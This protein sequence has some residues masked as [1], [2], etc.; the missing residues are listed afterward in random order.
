MQHI[1]LSG[2]STSTSNIQWIS[3]MHCKS[4]EYTGL[5]F[6]IRMEGDAVNWTKVTL[7]PAKLF[8]KDHMVK[9]S[10]EFANSC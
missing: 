5:P 2:H 1:W 4:N 7:D 3:S 8:L 10:I 6:S 9:P